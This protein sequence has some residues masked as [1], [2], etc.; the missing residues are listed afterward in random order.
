ME[1][2]WAP[3]VFPAV[4]SDPV[5]GTKQ[6]GDFKNTKYRVLQYCHT[7]QQARL[8][9]FK[10]IHQVFCGLDVHEMFNGFMTFLALL[11]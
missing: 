4:Q 6:I 3:I 1:R 10:F 7:T 8:G 5:W 9:G 2:S 11:P